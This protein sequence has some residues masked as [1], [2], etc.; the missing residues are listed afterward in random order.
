MAWISS[1]FVVYRVGL[2]WMNWHRP[3]N[4]L[5]NCLDNRTDALHISP[6]T[7]DNIKNLILA[8]LLIGSYALLF[9]NWRKR[10]VTEGIQ[11]N[12]NGE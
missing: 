4:C 11:M 3:C 2:W 7:A 9:L 6:Q 8:Y 5:C 12:S 1:D 10:S